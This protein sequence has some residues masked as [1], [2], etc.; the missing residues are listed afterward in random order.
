[1]RHA[2]LGGGGIGGLIAAA[3]ARAGRDVVLLLRQETVST[4]GGCLEVESAV[5]GN[6]AGRRAGGARRR[7]SGRPVPERH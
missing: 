2:V 6:F 7:R 3:L 4:Y 5:L 1:M